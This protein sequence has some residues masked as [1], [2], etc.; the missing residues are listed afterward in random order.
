[1][2]AVHVKPCRAACR[3]ACRVLRSR[4]RIHWLLAALL[5]LVLGQAVADDAAF[6]PVDEAFRLTV[7][8]DAEGRPQLHFALAPDYHLYRDRLALAAG[9]GGAEPLALELPPARTVYDRNFDQDM[10]IY[11]GS[12][13]VPIGLST[14]PDNGERR[15]LVLD[16]Q[17]CADAGLCYPPQTR[18]LNLAFADD[19]RLAD[20]SMRDPYALAD[21]AGTAG[22]DATV[23]PPPSEPAATAATA[24]SDA[25]PVK[26]PPSDDSR[27]AGALQSG[28]LGLIAGVF[29]L[30]GV[31]LSFTPCVLPM[32]P[33]LSAIIVG[34]REAVSRSRGLMLSVAYV[35]GMALVYTLFGIAAGLL[36]EGLAAFLQN[37]W[38]LGAFGLLLTALA[39]SMFGLWELQMPSSLQ[40]RL[41]LASGK[42]PGGQLSGVFLMGGL[43]AMIVGPCV[44]GP[45]AGALI[46]ISQTRDVVIGGVALFSLACGMSVPLLLVGVS[47]GS[48]LPKTGRW[49][50]SVKHVFGVMLLAVAWWLVSPVLPDVAVLLLFAGLLA[51][52]AALLGAFNDLESQ[53]GLGRRSAKAA[54]W[55]LAC[56][57]AAQVIGALAG[58]SSPWQPLQPLAGASTDATRIAFQRV[59]GMAGLDAALVAARG[60]PVLVD[61]YADWCVACKELEHRT[62]ADPRVR[63]ALS[64]IV[65]LQADVTGN[66]PGDRELL[67]RYGLFGPPGVL[68]FDGAG[69]EADH[70]RMV[71]FEGPA[72]F[73]ERLRRAY[74]GA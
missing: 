63:A 24:V 36:G 57:A 37:P 30:A 6:L 67:K 45:L 19:G 5:S 54:G 26:A 51:L 16:Y 10:A 46:Y 35:F 53:A 74:Q 52:A 60:K 21:A 62:F 9:D 14:A 13:T 2:T 27:I 66:Q 44:A 40:T 3:D 55:L 25:P 70:A 48:L 12:L 72:D 8:A 4:L 11:E 39:A 42:L 17:G 7:T 56:G 65:L 50:E 34:Q 15:V 29:L 38:V 49:M 22:A 71:G 64:E 20:A 68:F 59:E 28:R 58:A 47:A 33:I 43:S 32:V 1:M 73:L 69:S 23:S 61:V 18:E 31:L 41:T